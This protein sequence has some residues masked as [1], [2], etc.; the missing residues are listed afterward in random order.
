MGQY[1]RLNA[2]YTFSKTLDD[3]T[4]TTF[5]S[6]PQD[7]YHRSLERGNSNQD[8]RHRFLANF[9]A[10]APKSKDTNI[11]LRDWEVSG[12]ITL[13][14]A[15]PFTIFVGHDAN[16]DT[17]PVTDRVGL[18][19]RNTY[20]GDKLKTVDLRFSRGFSFR[21]HQKLELAADVFNVMNRNNVDEVDSVYTSPDFCGTAPHN[22]NDAVSKKIQTDPFSFIGSCTGGVP[23]PNPDF[24][25]PRK[26]FNARQFQLS[27]KYS[28]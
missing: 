22:Y 7:L 23:F 16:N 18:A 8:V 9:T 25:R 19:A 27:F 2:N 1:F 20:W 14:G 5:V 13:Q 4:F 21:E 11:A 15:R 3:G 28:F 6:T 17:N 10:A 26:V 12:I 24:G